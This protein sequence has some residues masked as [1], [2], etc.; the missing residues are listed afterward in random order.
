MVVI[1]DLAFWEIVREPPF[2]IGCD[3]R[4]IQASCGVSQRLAGKI[5]QPHPDG[6]VKEAR[7]MVGSG[8]KAECGLWGDSFFMQEG[9]EGIQGEL[10][11]IR[12]K[13]NGG[14]DF[15]F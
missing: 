4:L 11:G 6:L 9:A 13:S 12:T 7:S 8:F 5:A 1:E 14:K 3:I 10:P 2:A 15:G